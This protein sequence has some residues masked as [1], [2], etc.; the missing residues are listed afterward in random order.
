MD[1]SKNLYNLTDEEISEMFKEY[2]ATYEDME[3][4]T[5]AANE[6][7]EQF[8]KYIEELFPTDIEKQSEMYDRMM[9]V[10]VEFEE[11]GFMAGVKWVLDLVRRGCLIPEPNPTVTEEFGN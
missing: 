4:H 2:I 11:S 8:D 5:K 7:V 9:D 1:R 10:A 6:E 3:R